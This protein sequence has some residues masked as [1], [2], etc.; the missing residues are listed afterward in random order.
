M[1]VR[2]LKRSLT[3]LQDK[4]KDLLLGKLKSIICLLMKAI[5]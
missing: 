3:R 1:E 2:Q 5:N 4:P